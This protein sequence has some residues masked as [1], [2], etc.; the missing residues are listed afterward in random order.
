L[1]SCTICLETD[2]DTWDGMGLGTWQWSLAIDDRVPEEET[3]DAREP[4][5]EAAQETSI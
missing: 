1:K 5:I 3:G 2:N 4:T